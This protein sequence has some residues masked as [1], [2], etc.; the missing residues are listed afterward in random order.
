MFF[1]LLQ[2]QPHLLS[3][4]INSIEWTWVS[5]WCRFINTSQIYI[6][7]AIED[8]QRGWYQFL[9]W[10]SNLWQS[11]DWIVPFFEFCSLIHS[12]WTLVRNSITNWKVERQ[13]HAAMI[14]NHWF[15]CEGWDL[16]KF[17]AEFLMPPINID[18]KIAWNWSQLFVRPTERIKQRHTSL[19]KW[20][21]YYYLKF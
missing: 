16:L 5:L 1:Y 10:I 8:I 3:T 12:D 15:R 2:V 20:N 17:G 6:T 11:M 18:N 21:L 19:H 9:N 13:A 4:F 14:W 7:N